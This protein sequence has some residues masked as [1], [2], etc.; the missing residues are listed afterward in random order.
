MPCKAPALFWALGFLPGPFLDSLEILQT[1]WGPEGP[2][3]AP[4]GPKG[5][6]QDKLERII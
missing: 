3:K 1:L 4:K 6:P 5:S 2:L